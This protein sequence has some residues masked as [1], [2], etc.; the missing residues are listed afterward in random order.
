MGRTTLPCR[1]AATLLAIRDW[2]QLGWVPAFEAPQAASWLIDG[3]HGTHA[4]QSIKAM[5]F[6]GFYMPG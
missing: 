3:Q 4:R 1:Q 6:R 2:L 5:I